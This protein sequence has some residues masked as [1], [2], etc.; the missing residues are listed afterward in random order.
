MP[1]NSEILGFFFLLLFLNKRTDMFNQLHRITEI[2]NRMDN[3]SGAANSI[4]DI[5]ALIQ[6]VGPM[7]SAFNNLQSTSSDEY[8]EENRN[9]IF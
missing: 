5:N 6:K 3:L 1:K 8:Y 9:S 7:M 4:S 2:L